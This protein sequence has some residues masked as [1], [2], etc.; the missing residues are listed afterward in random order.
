MPVPRA[1][2]GRRGGPRNSGQGLILIRFQRQTNCGMLP[3]CPDHV[4]STHCSLR[5]RRKLPPLPP[6]S[7]RCDGVRPCCCRPSSEPPSNKRPRP[8]ACAAPPCRACKRLFAWKRRRTP[9]RL[10]LGVAGA[11]RYSLRRPSGPSSSL[12]WSGRQAGPSWS[13]PR[14]GPPWR[15]SSGAPS[16]P[17]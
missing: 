3:A 4:G 9:S 2:T 13:F 1:A 5:R 17:R 10:R 11:V 8:W 15:N 6:R 16:S 12:G 7:R 14:C